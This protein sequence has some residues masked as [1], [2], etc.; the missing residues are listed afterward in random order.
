MSSDFGKKVKI[1]IFGQSHSE[2][3][4]VV[5]DGLPVGE[6]IDLDEV[7]KFMERRAPGRNAYSTPRKEA[8]LPRVVS[9]LFEGKTCGAPVCAIIEN[10]NTRSKDYDKLKDLPRPG[11]ADFTAW[12]KYNGY[13]DHRGGGHFSGRLTAPLCFAGAVCKQILERKGIHVGAHI[14][15]IK[16]VKDVPFDAVE[17]DAET[18]KAVAGKAFPVQNDAAGEEM[19]AVIAAVKEKGDSVGGIVECAITGLPVGVGEPMF[20]GL[21]SVLAQAIF[22]IPAVKGVEFG[23]GFAVADLFGSENNDDFM[24]NEDGTVKT[25][26]NNHGGS[27][28]G[29]SSGMPMVF[30]AAFKP[31]PSISMEQDTISISKRENDR[32]AV[33]GRHDPC[34]VPRAV[35]VVEA[36]AAVAILDLLCG[37]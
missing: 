21:E 8:D 34:I 35:P 10:T 37:M 31:T 15:S 12:V 23:A 5:M 29:I 33:Q 20:D 2:A 3:I 6:E 4:G 19:Q 17:I 13:N 30:R 36:A 32:L 7:Q 18:L 11:H 14:L 22:A 1:Q 9:G 25:K 26:T 27:L 24:Y 16:G 28:G